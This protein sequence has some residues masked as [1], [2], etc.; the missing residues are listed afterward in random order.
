[1]ELPADRRATDGRGPARELARDRATA[2]PT[3]TPF[4]LGA[5]VADD[6]FVDELAGGRGTP[7]TP[8]LAASIHGAVA[9]AVLHGIYQVE[10]QQTPW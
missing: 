8:A 7:A 6:R 3:V 10:T 2:Q 9:V 5:S 1:M 4:V